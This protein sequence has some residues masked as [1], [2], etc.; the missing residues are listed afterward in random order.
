MN[1]GILKIHL[2][3]PENLSL[4]GKRQVLK[5]IIAQLRN[6]FNVSVAEVADND[7]WQLAT[8]AVCAVSNDQRFTNEVLSKAVNLVENGRFEMEMLDYEIEIIS[9]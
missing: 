1:I 9:L 4:K 3:L 8:I 6:R 2:R 5:S 7:L